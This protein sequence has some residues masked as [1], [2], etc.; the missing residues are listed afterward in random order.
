MFFHVKPERGLGLRGRVKSV[1]DATK[2]LA[3]G[4][5]NKKPGSFD[6]NLT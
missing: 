4:T 1:A 5:T 6:N 2:E 3:W